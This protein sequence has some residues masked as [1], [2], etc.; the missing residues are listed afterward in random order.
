MTP[1]AIRGEFDRGWC[2]GNYT[3]AYETEN[4][5][6][7]NVSD[8]AERRGGLQPL[9][10]LALAQ[11]WAAGFILGFF[12]SYED[13]EIPERHLEDVTAARSFEQ[14]LSDKEHVVDTMRRDGEWGS[15]LAGARFDCS[16]PNLSNTPKGR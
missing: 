8:K 15:N 1:E 7:V 10:R 3:N 6:A 11:A 16:K 12:S 13:H 9:D 4:L 5:D 14:E 2:C